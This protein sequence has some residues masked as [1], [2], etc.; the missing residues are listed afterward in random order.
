MASNMLETALFDQTSSG[1]GAEGGSPSGDVITLPPAAIGPK[2]QPLNKRKKKKPVKR[3]T[4]AALKRQ[5]AAA[6]AAAASKGTSKKLKKRARSASSSDSD[7]STSSSASSASSEAK[8]R[9]RVS[10]SKRRSSRKSSSSSPSFVAELEDLV[11]YAAHSAAAYVAER[12]GSNRENGHLNVQSAPSLPPAP[13]GSRWR[14][15]EDHL[16]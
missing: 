4:A 6:A 11:K 13:T 7:T 10:L 3:M 16:M 15:I 5:E 9:R 14:R 8:V 2:K 1:A 12:F